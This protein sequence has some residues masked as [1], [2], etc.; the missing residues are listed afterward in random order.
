L[1]DICE[2]VKELEAENLELDKNNN[3][4]EFELKKL[5]NSKIKSNNQIKQ[6]Q[7]EIH[8]WKK[9]TDEN[10]QSRDLI[11]DDLNEQVV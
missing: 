6:L 8:V 11:I 9:S 3:T 7:K 4:L 5:N 10:T 1:N 2:A